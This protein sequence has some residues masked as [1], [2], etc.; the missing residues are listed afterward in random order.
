[1]GSHSRALRTSV[2]PKLLAL[3]EHGAKAQATSNVEIESREGG[4]II[5]VA[6]MASAGDLRLDFGI[7]PDRAEQLGS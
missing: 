4:R 3:W 7:A 5:S 2:Y 1:M 6:V